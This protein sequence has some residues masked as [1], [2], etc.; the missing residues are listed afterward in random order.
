MFEVVEHTA[1][2]GLRIEAP[3]W[4]T[5]LSESARAL[6]TL[7]VPNVASVRGVEE[8]RIELPSESPENLLVDWLSEL[9]FVFEAR[10]LVLGKF[11]VTVDDAGLHA[12]ARAEKLDPSRHEVGYEIKAITYHRL[13]VE[14]REQGWIAEVFLDI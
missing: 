6:F 11:A 5:L 8:L 12:V 7:L 3:D 9:L 13:R 2:V 1:D 4:C 14:E 10:R